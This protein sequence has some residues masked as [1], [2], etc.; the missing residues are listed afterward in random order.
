MRADVAL[1]FVAFAPDA[2]GWDGLPFPEHAA[3]YEVECEDGDVDGAG[4]AVLI[5]FFAAGGERLVTAW[6]RVRALFAQRQGYLGAR[7]FGAAGAAGFPVVAV[8]RWSSPLMHAR[9]L[10]QPDV[11]EAIAALPDPGRPALYL[12]VPTP[13]R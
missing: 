8:V 1:R 10:E 11:R 5:D 3:V 12:V 6:E 9:A 2:A 4:G 13:G 7:L